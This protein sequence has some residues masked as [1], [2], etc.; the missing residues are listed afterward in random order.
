MKTSLKIDTSRLQ[1]QLLLVCLAWLLCAGCGHPVPSEHVICGGEFAEAERL[2]GSAPTPRLASKDF[3]P[4][5]CRVMGK[6]FGGS[7]ALQAFRGGPTPVYQLPGLRPG[8]LIRLRADRLS[9]VGGRLRACVRVDGQLRWDI[10]QRQAQTREDGSGRLNLEFVVPP[11][12]AGHTLTV[13]LE[14]GAQD[15]VTLFEDL[16]VEVL[17]KALVTAAFRRG[18]WIDVRDGRR[19]PVVHLGQNWWLAEDYACGADSGCAYADA[20]ASLPAP[21]RLPSDRDWAALEA[22]VG[23]PQA[24]LADSGLRGYMPQARLRKGGDTGIDILPTGP[25]GA[26]SLGVRYWS[27]S[28]ADAGRYWIRH[29]GTEMGIERLQ[30]DAKQR[31]HMRAVLR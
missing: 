11:E 29:F 10:S 15:T 22:A 27:S 20:A 25:A 16:Y 28:E 19:Y 1:F 31:I 23:V 17:P 14:A 6:G 21:L 26:D 2:V 18:I 30:A 3:G 7:A 13:T 24:A 9:G 4:V 12:L 8:E 5:A